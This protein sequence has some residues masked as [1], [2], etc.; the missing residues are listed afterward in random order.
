MKN[1]TMVTD[2]LGNEFTSQQAMCDAYE[3]SRTTYKRRLERGWTQEAALTTPSGNTVPGGS[4]A[5][6]CNDES[7]A[8]RQAQ[9][10][11]RQKTYR[12]S[13][14][15]EIL[16]REKVYRDANKEKIAARHK[17]YYKHH[18]EKRLAYGKAYREGHEATY[19]KEERNA[20]NKAYYQEHK[21][22]ILA[23]KKARYE[24]RKSVATV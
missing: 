11:A 1:N 2:H 18:K 22:E 24:A 20:Y 16:A 19:N 15:E 13:H 3:I 8:A 7:I 12:E 21:E 14:K 10:K 4:N 6:V 9:S 5:Y 17:A 23:R